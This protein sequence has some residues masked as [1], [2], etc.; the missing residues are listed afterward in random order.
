VPNSSLQAKD[1][2]QHLL[3]AAI[4]LPIVMFILIAF[5]PSHPYVKS[6]VWAAIAS[7]MVFLFLVIGRAIKKRW[8]GILIDE[9]NVMTLSRFQII[10]W[11][12]IILSAYFT[13]VGARIY[14]GVKDSLD[15]DIDPTLWAL[16]GISS[17]SFVGTPLILDSKKRKTIKNDSDIE[18]RR[19]LLAIAR[20]KEKDTKSP[21]ARTDI[22]E[23]TSR[24]AIGVVLEAIKEVDKERFKDIK[25]QEIIDKLKKEDKE[26]ITIQTIKDNYTEGI[27]FVNSQDTEA[28]FSDIFEG[29]EVGNEGHVDVSKVQMFFFTIISAL[30]YVVMLVA[31]FADA[32]VPEKLPVLNEGLIAILTIS[33]GA[34]LTNKIVDHT[35]KPTPP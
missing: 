23:S 21:E 29:D 3:V 17:T 33:H 32:S 11:T 18:N 16:M 1:Y 24:K 10:I 19:K 31:M 30:S 13:I 27:L 7:I 4:I 14:A 25:D 9:R 28:K 5:F 8:D 35:T 15:V 20:R 22:V 26:A 2:G 34:Y 12:I 6:L